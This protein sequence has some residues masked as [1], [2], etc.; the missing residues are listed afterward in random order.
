[1]STFQPPPTWANPVLVDETTGKG[2]FNPV[3]LKWFIELSA[4]LDATGAGSGTVVG[5]PVTTPGHM[6]SWQDAA[7]T[8]IGD[9][10][11]IGDAAHLNIGTVAGTVC[12]GDDS[13]LGAGTT[14]WIN[15]EID[16]GA[17]PA[18][19]LTAVIIDAAITPA[20]KIIILPDGTASAG[21]TSDDWQWDGA[22][23]AGVA[24]T[25]QF[26]LY[27]VFLP[28]PVVGKRNILYRVA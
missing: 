13:R 28:G 3:W 1:M 5:V 24:G 2:S 7:A 20:D 16:A 9:G 12:A 15:A 18:F 14:S 6:A 23:F 11:V 27:A 10:G 19:D 25:G 26:T 17:K 21:R 4:G 8:V 22:S